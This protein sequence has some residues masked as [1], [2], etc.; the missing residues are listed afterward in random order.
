MLKVLKNNMVSIK[1][2]MRNKSFNLEF[3]IIFLFN[4]LIHIMYS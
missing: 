2:N 4:K 1:K 3:L